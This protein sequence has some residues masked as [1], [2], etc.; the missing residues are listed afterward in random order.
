MRWVLGY[1]AALCVLVLIVCQS[2]AI[3]TFLQAF[4]SHEYDKYSVPETISTEKDELMTVTGQ[5]LDYMHGKRADLIIPAVVDG[6]QRDF[7]NEK[8]IA[9]MADVR[10]LFD[11][12]FRVR[13][14][15]FW[16]LLLVVLA[17]F[18]INARVLFVLSRCCREVLAAFLLLAVILVV[19]IALDFDRAFNIFHMLFF[20]NDLWQL[21]P[22]TDL[23]INIVPL[24]FFM[25]IAVFI[26][27]L[28]ASLS[29]AI[30]AA[31]TV[32]LRRLYGRER[33][34]EHR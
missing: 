4:Y 28:I 26:G 16:L 25:D 14:V 1:V 17:L 7:F 12:G 29:L 22:A 23:L 34:P 27:S 3:P 20:S 24:G 5:L 13:N 8:E 11:I 6:Q 15:A 21:N 33:Y 10:A 30:I 2:I 32:Y 19:F 18:F 31:S 9:H